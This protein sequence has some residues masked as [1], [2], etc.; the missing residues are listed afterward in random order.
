MNRPKVRT[1]HKIPPEGPDRVLTLA[2]AAAAEALA[3]GGW[4]DDKP[5]LP[6]VLGTNVGRVDR[7]NQ[8]RVIDAW[9]ATAPEQI[10][11]WADHHA[12]TQALSDRLGL[13]GPRLGV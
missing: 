8:I 7:L 5:N 6:L 4:P 11:E 9:E 3:A 10:V 12:L 1:L 13:T 2:L